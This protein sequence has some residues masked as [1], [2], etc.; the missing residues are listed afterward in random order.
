MGHLSTNEQSRLLAHL[1]SGTIEYG[2]WTDFL[3]ILNA[4]FDGVN[5]SLATVDAKSGKAIV[6]YTSRAFDRSWY[7]RYAAH[8]AKLSPLRPI[9]FRRENIGRALSCQ[10]MMPAEE[11]EKS[12][13][14]NDYL[15]DYD[16]RHLLASVFKVSEGTAAYIALHRSRRVGHFSTVEI[17]T[18][19]NLLPHLALAYRIRSQMVGLG[20][21]EEVSHQYLDAKGKGLVCLDRHGR[22]VSMNQEAERILAACDGLTHAQSRLLAQHP[23]DDQRLSQLVTRN[24]TGETARADEIPTGGTMTVRRA[25]GCVPYGLWVFPVIARAA[26]YEDNQIA[27][28]I[29]ITDPIARPDQSARSALAG[30]GLTKA[31]LRLAEALISGGQLKDIALRFDVSVNTLKVQRRS[32]YRKVG[33]SRHFDLLQLVRRDV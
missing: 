21:H 32:L 5:C 26:H 10:R 11:F 2:H 24:C 8:Y 25:S 31:E 19:Q 6:Q 29:E 14:C 4:N 30:Y 23:E 1:Y 28:A 16:I 15:A 9:L 17:D 33:A 3:R 13:F 12:E 7:E 27:A 18:L 20:R 22:V